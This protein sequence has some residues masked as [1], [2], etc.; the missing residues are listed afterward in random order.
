MCPNISYVWRI[1]DNDIIFLAIPV[2]VSPDSCVVALANWLSQTNQLTA[3]GCKLQVFV[4]A[5]EF[6]LHFDYFF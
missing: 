6:K 5:F 2:V 3:I 1:E 4:I